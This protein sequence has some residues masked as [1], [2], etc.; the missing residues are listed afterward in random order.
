VT[1]IQH[2]P[3]LNIL[4]DCLW[5]YLYQLLIVMNMIKVL[6]YIKLIGKFR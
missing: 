4:S 1:R 5:W 6:G 2:F 3:I